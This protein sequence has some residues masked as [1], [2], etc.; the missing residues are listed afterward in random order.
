MPVEISTQLSDLADEFNPSSDSPKPDLDASA[1]LEDGAITQVPDESMM[2]E[3][4]PAQDIPSYVGDYSDTNP[5][6]VE[7]DDPEPVMVD[8]PLVY[9][10]YREDPADYIFDAEKDK[11]KI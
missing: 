7:G 5:V 4:L 2:S 3:D 1:P 6:E 9:D 10:N 11:D 8:E